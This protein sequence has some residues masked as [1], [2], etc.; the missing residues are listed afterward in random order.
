MCEFRDKINSAPITGVT[1]PAEFDDGIIKIPKRVKVEASTW[2]R[3]AIP[4]EVTRREKIENESAEATQLAEKLFLPFPP[5][6]NKHSRPTIRSKLNQKIADL[7]NDPRRLEE[8]RE[9]RNRITAVCGPM[10][11]YQV[12]VKE[13]YYSPFTKEERNRK[14]YIEHENKI[15]QAKEKQYIF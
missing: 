6:K 2:Q 15:K 1:Y 12:K 5:S 3:L 4:R 11:D 9:Y 8:I 7:S 10:L 14:K 13:G